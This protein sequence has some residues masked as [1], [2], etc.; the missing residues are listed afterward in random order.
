MGENGSQTPTAM[1][2]AVVTISGQLA[3][4]C[5]NGIRLVRMMWMISVCVSSDS[6]NQPV[7]NSDALAPGPSSRRRRAS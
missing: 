2:I 7:W 5:R 1:M 6:T 4:L 3:Q